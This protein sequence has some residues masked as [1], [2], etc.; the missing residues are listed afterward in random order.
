MAEFERRASATWEGDLTG[1]RG[2]TSTESGALREA[3]MA[4]A[5]RFQD[6]HG[7]NPEELI[8]AA[9]ATCYSMA[10]ANIL[11]QGGHRA[12]RI[13]TDASVTLSKTAEGFAI[14]GV[15]LTVEASVPGLDDAGFQEAA[16]KAKDGCPVSRLLKPG[17]QRLS[18]DAKL[19]R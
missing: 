16:A 3:P 14:T 7:S 18:V 4:F 6:S 17:L 15:R 5:S 13:R 11:S 12:E 1:G 10:L 8:A 19:A 9:H 2:A